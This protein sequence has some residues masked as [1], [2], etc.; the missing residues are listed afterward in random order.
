LFC[1][2]EHLEFREV[3]SLDAYPG[4]RGFAQRFGTRSSAKSTAFK[5]DFPQ[6]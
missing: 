6:T 5:F 2:V 3:L 4:L 1:L